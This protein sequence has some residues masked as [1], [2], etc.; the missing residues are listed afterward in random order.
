MAFFDK[1]GETLS[2]TGK[3]VAKKAKELAEVASLNGQITTQE[4]CI[5]KTFAE[6]GKMVYQQKAEWTSPELAEKIGVVDDAYA[7]IERLKKELMIV[8]GVKQCPQCGN[9]VAREAA[10]CSGCGAAVPVEEPKAEEVDVPEQ[11]EETAEEA[12]P[13]QAAAPT[14]PNCNKEVAEGSSFCSECGTK[15][16]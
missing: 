3:D 7:E 16:N 12:Q 4:D 11:A 10:F 6:I 1:L 5:N 13:E 2:N 8:K 9:E 15:L 14:C